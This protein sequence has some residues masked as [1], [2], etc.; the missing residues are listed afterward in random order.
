VSAGLWGKE[1]DPV[2]LKVYALA[3]RFFRT[4]EPRVRN[5]FLPDTYTSEQRK[6]CA[7]LDELP[8]RNRNG[9][10]FPTSNIVPN[11]KAFRFGPARENDDGGGEDPSVQKPHAKKRATLGA[12]LVKKAREVRAKKGAP[13]LKKRAPLKRA[14]ICKRRRCAGVEDK[15]ASVPAGEGTQGDEH[16]SGDKPASVPAGEGTQGDEHYSGDQGG[17][18][19]DAA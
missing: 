14:P 12:V 15:P 3:R 7:R 11:K 10:A 5:L 8:V 4:F 18:L 2:F 13:G 16:Y 1:K 9:Q 6:M 17:D 19:E